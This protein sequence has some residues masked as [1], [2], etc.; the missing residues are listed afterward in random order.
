[1]DV[2]MA[3]DMDVAR[4]A[5]VFVGNGWSSFT[6]NIVYRRLV[7]DQRLL[8]AARE[9]NDDLIQ[10]IFEDEESFDINYQ[11]GLG[12]TALHYAV[13]H[14][15][16]AVLEHILSHDNCDVDPVNRIDQQTPLHLAVKIS[17]SSARLHFVE[18]LLE[19]GADTTIKDKYGER[20]VDFIPDG[21]E[22]NEVRKLFRKE[23]AR[24]MISKDDVASD[25]DGEPGSGSG[26][27]DD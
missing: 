20:A 27:D 5:A 18:Q 22:G 15:S 12:N 9:D 26:S 25:D 14:L 13:I 11:D 2:N 4:R 8:A 17:N 16:D 6:S 7:D 21:P 24:S 23:E 3:V 19:A 10:E 1:M